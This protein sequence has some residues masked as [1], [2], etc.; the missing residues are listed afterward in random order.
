MTPLPQAPA[1]PNRSGAAPARPILVIQYLRAVAALMVVLFHVLGGSEG[2]FYVGQAGVD[3]FFVISGFIMWTVTSHR[4]QQPGR[5]LYR[6][7]LRIIP[8]YWSITLLVFARRYVIGT[9]TLPDLAYSLLFI[10]H[11]MS[12]GTFDPI[13]LPGWT[14][15]YEMF[16]YAV[17]AL[18]LWISVARRL[19]IITLLLTALVMLGLVL[20]GLSAAW[21]AVYLNS[22]LLEFLAGAWIG[23]ATARFK[24]DQPVI[25][26]VMV[27][28]CLG[29][30]AFEQVTQIHLIDWRVLVFGL[31]S[32]G[33]LIG[34]LALERFTPEIRPLK[35]LG[36]SSYAIYLVHAPIISLLLRISMPLPLRVLVLLVLSI[37]VG[38]GF[39]AADL[40]LNRLLR[41]GRQPRLA[42]GAA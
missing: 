19:T 40:R 27:G 29:I 4:E 11:R 1:V 14:L 6:R 5:F 24:L 10:P 41:R 9:A 13:V 36:D 30:L 34:L 32:V 15:N 21:A 17:F 16:F 42:P 23:Y 7:L 39:H 18:A 3:V 22:L 38:I 37:V 8:L 26:M 20:Q 12:D 33:L 31:P 28:Y 35:L 2:A 25:G